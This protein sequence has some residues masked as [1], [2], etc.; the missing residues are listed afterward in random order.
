MYIISN[1][2]RISSIRNVYRWSCAI[3][4]VS[5][6][7]RCCC[8]CI[9]YY[10][11]VIIIITIIIIK[12]RCESRLDMI[13]FYMVLQS[14]TKVYVFQNNNTYNTDHRHLIWCCKVYGLY[15]EQRHSVLASYEQD[16]FT[17][18]IL[19]LRLGT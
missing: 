12:Y 16:L 7:D 10:Y 4:D 11:K 1:A 2:R 9:I 3:F 14:L 13:R 19:R 5:K 15:G 18:N 6:I 8:C 17:H